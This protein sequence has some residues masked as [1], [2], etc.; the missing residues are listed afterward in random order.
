MGTGVMKGI[1]WFLVG[2]VVAAVIV[3]ATYSDARRMESRIMESDTG[4]IRLRSNDAVYAAQEFGIGLT[5]PIALE[6]GVR[7]RSCTTLGVRER[8]SMR[9]NTSLGDALSSESMIA[10][11]YDYVG[12]TNFYNGGVSPGEVA[13]Q[14]G[15]GF[16][17][18]RLMTSGFRTESYT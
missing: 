15:G 8:D 10:S 1:E 13:V 9:S 14:I 16:E 11:S 4:S 12:G 17:T 5:Q 3:F 6:E 7:E 2:S 18:R